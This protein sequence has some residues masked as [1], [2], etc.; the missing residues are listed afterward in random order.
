[1][2]TK[3]TL[4]IVIIKDADRIRIKPGGDRMIQAPRRKKQA[5]PTLVRQSSQRILT[6]SNHDDRQGV[7]VRAIDDLRGCYRGRNDTPDQHEVQTGP[8]PGWSRQNLDGFRIDRLT[9]HFER[10]IALKTILWVGWT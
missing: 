5:M 6:G 3:V 9:G 1:M 7:S 10:I 2:V 8:D 4:A